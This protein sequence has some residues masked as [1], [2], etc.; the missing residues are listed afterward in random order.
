[1]LY[2]KSADYIEKYI[3]KTVFS[4]DKIGFIDLK[5]FIFS[6]QLKN[7]HK[8]QDINIF[9][10]FKINYTIIWGDD[11][12]LAPEYLYFLAFQNE[13]KLQNKFQKWGYIK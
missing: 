5:D 11:L 7:F 3:I 13:L 8:L 9:K 1:M 6:T 12:D 10:D 2:I 4:D